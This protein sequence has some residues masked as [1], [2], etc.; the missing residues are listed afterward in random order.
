MKQI[1]SKIKKTNCQFLSNVSHRKSL[2]WAVV[3]LLGGIAV[4]LTSSSAHKELLF[5][6]TAYDPLNRS[7]TAVIHLADGKIA[8]PPI[9][10]EG[11]DGF[12]LGA[13]KRTV[14][15]SCRFGEETTTAYDPESGE[16]AKIDLGQSQL[17]TFRTPL[18]CTTRGKCFYGFGHIAT[19][20]KSIGRIVVTDGAVVQKTIVLPDA[21]GPMVPASLHVYGNILYILGRGE[22]GLPS[23]IYR[24]DITLGEFIG[25][26][27][28]V[29]AEAWGMAIYENH[30]AVSVFRTQEG[31]DIFILN[32]QTGERIT[33]L[34]TF[35]N[36]PSW[37]VFGLVFTDENLIAVGVGGITSFDR[38]SWEKTIEVPTTDF[39]LQVVTGKDSLFITVPNLN[40]IYEYT[41]SLDSVKRAFDIK[42]GF[43]EITYAIVTPGTFFSRFFER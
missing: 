40:K 3:L 12:A 5:V 14:R 31:E 29:G 18:A 20:T 15:V 43:G 35:G 36:W 19:G 33:S 37:N 16:I 11:C 8:I 24:V 17:S 1:Y 7:A 13:D 10:A 26:P 21:P 22:T 41:T 6:S 32:S 4:F 25:S 39:A 27:I 34:S 23:T 30:L 38:L 28:E 42:V 9:N 2:L